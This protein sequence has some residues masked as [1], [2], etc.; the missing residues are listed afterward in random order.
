MELGGA[1]AG[2]EGEETTVNVQTLTFAEGGGRLNVFS[3]SYQLAGLAHVTCPSHAGMEN[4]Q[5]N[6]KTRF[7]LHKSAI[8]QQFIFSAIHHK[9]A[10]CPRRCKYLILLS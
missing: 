9:K 2:G 1:G 8:K 10:N 7:M 4:K 5:N 3:L 6:K